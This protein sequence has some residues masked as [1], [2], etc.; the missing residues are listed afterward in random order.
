MDL[1]EQLFKLNKIGIAL[2]SE[3]NLTNIL[4]LILAESRSFT[5]AEAGTLFTREGDQLRFEVTQNEII[6]S[7]PSERNTGR[8]FKADLIPMTKS[9]LSGYCAITG[10]VLNIPDA[11]AIPPSVEYRFNPDFDRRNNYLTKSLLVV[12]MK[13]VGG[14]VLGVLQLINARN[15]Q[16]KVVPFDP[17]FESLVLSLASQAAVAY[18]NA[19]LTHDL[20]DAYLDTIMRL[21]IAAEFRDN[22][23]AIHIR[24]MSQY[25]AAIAEAYGM[26]ADEVEQILYAS[27]MHDIGKIGVSDSILRK[28]GRLTDQEFAEMKQHTVIGAAILEGAE[29]PVLKLSCEIALAHHEKWDG[30]GYPY[31][32]KGAEIPVSARVV[33]VADVFDALTSVRCYKPA[34]PFEEAVGMIEKGSGNHFEPECVDAFKRA[35]P[36]IVEIKKAFSEEK[37]DSHRLPGALPSAFESR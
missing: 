17:Q 28:P 34:F 22:D 25:S 24:R 23:T 7:R 16:G 26:T 6:A 14:E 10:E 15:P 21:S 18:W 8:R 19:K 1:R 30:S 36:R 29:A 33:A 3:R 9:S 13:S 2:S 32:R 5:G 27:P 37:S 12:P 31:G 4:D 11:Y 35:L 20:K